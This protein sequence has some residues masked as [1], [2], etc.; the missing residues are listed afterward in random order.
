MIINLPDTDT[1]VIARQLVTLRETG[2]IVT[3]GRVL[4]LIVLAQRDDDLETIIK[5]EIGRAS[6]RERV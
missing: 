6:C 2:G 3:T 1:R 4:T 5:T